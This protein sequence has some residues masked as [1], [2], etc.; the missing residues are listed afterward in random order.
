MSG[1]GPLALALETSTGLGSLAVGE[2]ADLLAE[3]SLGVRAV[4][5]ETVLP[6][7]ERLLER[8]GRGPD[9]LRRVVVGAGP[10]SFTGVRIAASIARGMCY[11]AERELFAYSSLAVV[12]A[13]CGA[14]GG[15]PVCA[16]F[17]ARRQEVYA[18]AVSGFRPLRYELEPAV[19]PL[20]ELLERLDPGDWLFAGE[21]ARAHR[22]AIAAAGGAVLPGFRGV[23]RAAALLWLSWSDPA[24]GRVEDARGWEP[25]YVRRPGARP[26]PSAV[27]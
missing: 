17:E 4:H 9:E 16:V 22:E 5:S 2:G 7:A 1:A 3:C 10:G 12:A 13:S 23:P 21:G 11:G 24:A 26:P 19:L 8:C 27:P 6:E 14:G 25:S 15:R 18:A 20:E